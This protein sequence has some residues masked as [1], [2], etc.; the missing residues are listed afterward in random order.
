MTDAKHESD[1]VEEYRIGNTTILISNVAYKNRTPEE[2]E[3]ILLRVAAIG[4]EIV[5]SART[6]GSDI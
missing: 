6:E 1:I 4:W 3:K 5:D 2:I